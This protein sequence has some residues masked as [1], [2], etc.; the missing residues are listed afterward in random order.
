MTTITIYRIKSARVFRMPKPE[1]TETT[2]RHFSTA[3]LSEQF[4]ELTADDGRERQFW[5]PTNTTGAGYLT[6]IAVA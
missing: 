2:E 6:C 1:M 5:K 3:Q 4:G